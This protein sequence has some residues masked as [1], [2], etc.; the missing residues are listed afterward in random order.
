[1]GDEGIVEPSGASFR[2]GVD[3]SVRSQILKNIYADVDVNF[4]NPR[5]KNE[6]EGMN[7]VPLAP[8]LTS[9][10]GISYQSKFGLQGSLRYRYMADRTANEDNT[11]IAKG[12]T[13]LDA[14][15]NYVLSNFTI[16]LS[17]QNFL[18]EVWNEAQ[19]DTLSQLKGEAIPVSEIHF[20]PGTSR[21]VKAGISWKF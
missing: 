9:S 7:Y 13:V 18:N 6:P 15:L 8:T 20:T 14:T 21:F 3:V 17:C 19:F 16:S 5:F 12:Y 11:V 2:K 4:A 10:G 1:M